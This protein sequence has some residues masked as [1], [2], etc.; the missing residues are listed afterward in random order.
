MRSH[1]T[2]TLGIKLVI[3]FAILSFCAL[4]SATSTQINDKSHASSY[5]ASPN[6]IFDNI[7]LDRFFAENPG[8]PLGAAKVYIEPAQ[9]SFSK[10]WMKEYKNQTSKKYRRHTLK[11]YATVLHEQV[12]IAAS[13]IPEFTIL[14][15]AKGADI[16]LK[17][18]LSSIFINGPDDNISNKQYVLIAG[19]ANFELEIVTAQEGRLLA[20]YEDREATRT[21]ARQASRFRN[22]QDFKILIEQWSLHAVKHFAMDERESRAKPLASSPN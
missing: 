4:A 3:G 8:F 22:R 17:P 19:M 15:S 21:N 16:I 18:K 9:A 14:N 11:S 5:T 10:E 20:R 2:K 7:T 13:Y 12:H 6:S 1:I